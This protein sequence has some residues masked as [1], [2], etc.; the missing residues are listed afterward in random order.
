MARVNVLEDEDVLTAAAAQAFVAAVTEAGR[1][2]GT[3]MVSLTGGRTP[4]RLYEM[5]ATDPWRRRIDWEYLHLFWG[6]ERN[7][8]PDHPDSNFGMANQALVSKVSIPPE[9]VHRMRGELPAEEAAGEYERQLDVAFHNA[10]RD[11]RSFDLMLLGVG[12][13]AHIA[14]LFPNSP[15]LAERHRRVTFVWARHLNTHRI[16][17]TPSTLLDSFRIVVLVS[18]ASKAAAVAAALEGP[19][20]V[21]RCP[22]QLLRAA[23]DRVH[24]FMDRSAAQ[25]L[26]GPRA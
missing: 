21:T 12:E 22:A 5:L 23:G 11:D 10:N 8:P 14:S 26:S 25:A 1:D 6:D 20:D 2:R 15:A 3:A 4:R 7:V 13:D 17:L 24:W 19:E 18:G 16:T 9:Q